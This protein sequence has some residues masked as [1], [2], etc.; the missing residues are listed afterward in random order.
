MK[1]YTAGY[2][3][4]TQERDQLFAGLTLDDMI[5]EIK[6]KSDQNAEGHSGR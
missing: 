1:L 4:Y 2:G 3:N 5:S 6:R